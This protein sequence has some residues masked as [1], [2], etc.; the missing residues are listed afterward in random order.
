M[1]WM[2]G[3]ILFILS[4]TCLLIGY[5]YKLTMFVIIGYIFF[6]TLG[7]GILATGLFVPIGWF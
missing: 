4:I 2:L 7:V 1:Y 6:L 5:K 3:L